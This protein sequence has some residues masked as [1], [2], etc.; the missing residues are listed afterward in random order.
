MNR[1]LSEGELPVGGRKTC[2][3]SMSCPWEGLLSGTGDWEA[4]EWGESEHDVKQKEG[5]AKNRKKAGDLRL[6]EQG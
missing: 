4:G 2:G 3:W 1:F 6:R 5:S